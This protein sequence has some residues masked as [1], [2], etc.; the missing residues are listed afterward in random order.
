MEWRRDGTV[1]RVDASERIRL[2]C[3]TS[4]ARYMNISSNRECEQQFYRTP[5]PNTMCAASRSGI[6]MVL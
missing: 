3:R 5:P 4:E 2:L 6:S 1:V